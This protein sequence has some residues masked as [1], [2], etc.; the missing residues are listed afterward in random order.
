M[1]DLLSNR[2][3]PKVANTNQ[4]AARL[5]AQ[6]ES[7]RRKPTPLA[8]LIP[9]LQQ[10]ADEHDALVAALQNALSFISCNAHLT[11]PKVEAH[12][13]ELHLRAAIKKATGES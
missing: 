7:L 10:A 3:V 5:R 6:C 13:I 4:L 2:G 1:S 8:D 12:P 9:L 11:H